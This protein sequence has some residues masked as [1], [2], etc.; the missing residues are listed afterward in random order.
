MLTAVREFNGAER[1]LIRYTIESTKQ[2]ETKAHRHSYIG[3][4]TP[5]STAPFLMTLS[6]LERLS[7]TKHRAVSLRQLSFFFSW[8]TRERL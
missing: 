5:Y 6:D 8:L 3:L 2:I 7:D 4:H 1:T